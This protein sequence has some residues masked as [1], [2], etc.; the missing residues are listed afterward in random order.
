MVDEKNSDIAQKLD[1]LTAL[2]ALG[3]IDGRPQNEQI[4][5]LSAAGYPPKE[6]ADVIGT[7]PN[8]IRVQLHSIRK[9]QKREGVK[10]KSG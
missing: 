6:I 2:I 10:R 7:T 3:L 9:G 5:L 1:R 4:K 8:S